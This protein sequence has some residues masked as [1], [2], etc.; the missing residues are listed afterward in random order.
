MGRAAAGVKGAALSK[1][2]EVVSMEV[3]SPEDTLLTI[4]ENGYGKRS[5]VKD[6]RLVHRSARGVITMKVT[7][8]TGPVVGVL[9]IA[10]D[11]DE[12]IAV[13]SGGKLIRTS[14]KDIRV[15]GRNTQGVRLVRLGDP[16]E[17]GREHVVSVA[18]VADKDSPVDNE[19]GEE[20]G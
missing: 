7:K 5:R 2:D 17:G 9:K 1:G 6:Y 20:A 12:F 19:A 13:T 14:A 8:K 11:D 18:P 10:S 16:E 3:V 4:A 15:M